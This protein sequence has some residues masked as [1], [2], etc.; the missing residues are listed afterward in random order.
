MPARDLNDAV[1]IAA[2]RCKKEGVLPQAA[3]SQVLEKAELSPEDQK[4]LMV[5]GGA[6]M[7]SAFIA[8]NYRASD[9]AERKALRESK[10]NGGFK[11]K[12]VIDAVKR[13]L[14][15]VI[16]P[17]ADGTMKSLADFGLADVSA[18]VSRAANEEKGWA[19]RRLWFEKARGQLEEYGAEA[20][21]DLPDEVQADLGYAAGEVW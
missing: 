16:L 3:F 10:R 1:E 8:R 6:A 9:P 17:A 19:A 14:R 12:T 21:K 15:E 2:V 5:T 11:K 7:V 13:K 20:V 4:R 18:W